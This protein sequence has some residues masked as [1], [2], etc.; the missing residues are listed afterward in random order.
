MCVFFAFLVSKA[1]KGN[2]HTKAK[3][4]PSGS[5]AL[6]N[7]DARARAEVMAYTGQGGRGQGGEGGG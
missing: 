5:R 3:C 4:P 1:C 7:A 2:A 6:P